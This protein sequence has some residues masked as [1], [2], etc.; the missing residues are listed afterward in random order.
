[1]TPSP[2]DSRSLPTLPEGARAAALPAAFA[3]ELATLVA[4]P[5]DSGEWAW[6]VKFD[7]YRILARI[8]A[9]EVRLFTRN[10]KD[11]T[12]RLAG[13]AAELARLPLASAW[14]DGEIVVLDAAGVSDFG[15]LQNAFDGAPERIL[16]FA[17]DVPWL[18]G[19]DLRAVPLETRRE[20][21]RARLG[22]GGPRVRYS[23]DS[24]ADPTEILRNACRLGLEGLIG[25]RLGSAYASRRS[26]DWIKLKCSQRQEFVIAGYT[27]P[28]GSR[29]GLGAL[30]LGIHDD[31]GRLQ[32]AGNVGTGF[33]T[34]TLAA[35]RR[36]LGAIEAAQS[37]FFG[38]PRNARGNWVRPELVAEVS[39]QEWTQDG[40]VRHAVFHGL[41]DDKAAA[42]IRREQPATAPRTPKKL[43]A[44][45]LPSH[46]ADATARAGA[47]GGAVSDPPLPR[48]RQPATPPLPAG[49]RVTH[50]E[51]VIDPSS[52]LTKRDLVDHYLRAAQ[53]MLPHLAGRPVAL[54]RAP[55]GIQGQRFFQKHAGS[56]KIEDLQELPVAL[57]PGHPPLIEI[58]SSTALI[59]AAQ[60]NVVEF[61][62]WNACSRVIEKP[63]RMT[64][65]LDP[66]DGVPWARIVEAAQSIRALLQALG[67]QAF[68]KTSGGKGLHVVVPLAPREGWDLVKDFSRDV[69]EHLAAA[70]P[71]RVVA[72]S[73]SA[74][75]VGRIFIDYLRNGR[76]ATTAAAFSARARPGLG[77][78]VPCAWDELGALRGGDHWTVA[79][80]RARLDSTDDPWA[81]YL[82]VRQTLGQARRALT[83]LASP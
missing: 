78:S 74:N 21:L 81:G 83:A 39:F 17:F 12:A 3:P 29:T 42:D 57:D 60:M 30:L 33:D 10:G 20:I 71:E 77:V 46:A 1:M 25:K 50:P 8:V 64:F 59:S 72:K 62:T 23:P 34:R 79:T 56:L 51:R 11:W 58:D 41:R 80:V 15:A 73:G 45:P 16:Y 40:K 31:D 70:A 9:G 68:V 14:I 26:A 65:D 53:R 35:L 22:D 69:V 48:R 63:D 37:P 67:L 44:G 47:G 32:Y 24:R 6:E 55:A 82:S 28:K 76:G 54:V 52:G 43:R 19:Q 4:A 2:G 13:I 38:A 66:G 61:H 27:E 75:R 5:P 18:D 36:R 49:V 7:G